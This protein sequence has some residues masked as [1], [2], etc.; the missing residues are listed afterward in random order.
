MHMSDSPSVCL[1][2]LFEE[3]IMSLGGQR[4][5]IDTLRQLRESLNDSKV[6]RTNFTHVYYVLIIDMISEHRNF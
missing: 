6:Y 5:L 2:A 3:K 1:F 4:R